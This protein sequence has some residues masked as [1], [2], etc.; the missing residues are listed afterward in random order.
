MKT[1]GG[2]GL[3]STH[4]Y[5]RHY[6]EVSDQVLVPAVLLPGKSLRYEF[7]RRLGKLHSIEENSAPYRV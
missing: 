3:S 6:V 2:V 5:P 7:D 4:S 1:Y